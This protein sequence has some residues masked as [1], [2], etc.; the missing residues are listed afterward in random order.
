M[1]R[2]GGRKKKYLA[3]ARDERLKASHIL[4]IEAEGVKA[5]YEECTHQCI[6]NGLPVPEQRAVYEL[7]EES[8]THICTV[9]DAQMKEGLFNGRTNL[10]VSAGSA[11]ARACSGAILRR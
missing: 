1:A 6:M 2:R 8:G 10:S 5:A 3:V 9:F 4:I 7:E 11:N